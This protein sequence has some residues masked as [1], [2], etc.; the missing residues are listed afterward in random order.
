MSSRKEDIVL[1]SL[2]DKHVTSC[3]CPEPVTST[4]LRAFWWI[5]SNCSFHSMFL[6][7]NNVR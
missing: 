4:V 6:K 1:C 2:N 5:L 7:A 3:V